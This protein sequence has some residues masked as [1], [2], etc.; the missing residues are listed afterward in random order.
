MVEYIYFV[1]C[2]GCE[3]E[4]FDF[5][6]EAKEYA[7]GLMSRHPE[8]HQTE[9]IR[10]DFGECVDSSNLGMVWSWQ[11]EFSDIPE[12]PETDA[13][14][15]FTK[16]DF[17]KYAD[18]Y[19]PD[20]DP[21]FDD[22]DIT[23]ET[24]CI[25]RKPVPADMTIDDLVEA[26]EENEDEVECGLC[27]ELYDKSQCRYEL[28]LGWLCKDCQADLI[29]RGESPTFRENNYW[30]FLDE[31][32]AATENDLKESFD[33]IDGT[34][35]LE[36]DKLKVYL[37]GSKRAADDWDELEDEVSYTYTVTKD[38]VATVLWEDLLEEA[39]VKYIEG[40]FDALE[41]DEAW[42]AFL[43]E[44]FDDLFEKYYTQLLKHFEDAAAEAYENEMSL[45][46]YK[47]MEREGQLGESCAVKQSMLEELEESDAY[48]S[49]L[50]LC[51]E[52]GTD[53]FDNETGICINCGFNVDD[54]ESLTEEL[55]QDD[56]DLI[57]DIAEE[58]VRTLE[59]Q[60][61]INIDE[62]YKKIEA[63]TDEILNAADNISAQVVSI[64]NKDR[65]GFKVLK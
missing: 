34:V 19:D 30:D 46:R 60:L 4:A 3:D 14:N 17:D 64:K 53:S 28:N 59:T 61:D 6:N 49:R 24:D 31:E 5:F 1:K 62:L 57:S 11:E 39:D 43:A 18:G 52:C 58:S 33:Y 27:D 7:R 50:T 63:E 32:V 54:T 44:R 20:N 15:I 23:F 12:A 25:V 35:D 41:D 55:D 38:D 10:N 16:G 51:P 47:A 48:R 42:K 26:M 45:E 2:N 21:E 9:V 36:Y 37:Q 8:I 56:I 13:T 29:S 40:G 22:R 65:N